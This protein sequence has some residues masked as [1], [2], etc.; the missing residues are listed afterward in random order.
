MPDD[1][2][3]LELDQATDVRLRRLAVARDVPAQGLMRDA[4][5][6]YLDRE[7]SREQVVQDA[8]AAWDEYQATGLH[9]TA[10]EADAWLERLENGEDCEPPEPHR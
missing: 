2:T 3:T 4:V 5:E 8:V 10:E 9:V 7:E 1:R 6:Q